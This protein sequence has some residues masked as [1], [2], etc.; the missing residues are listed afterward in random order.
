L[1]LKSKTA[2]GT[3]A[4]CERRTRLAIPSSGLVIK[5]RQE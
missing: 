2:L 5:N 1:Q 3:T 4:D